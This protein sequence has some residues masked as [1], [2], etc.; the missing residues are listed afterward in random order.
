M[1][2]AHIDSVFS[3]T[4]QNS[5]WGRG[6]KAG[7]QRRNKINL[8]QTSAASIIHL[9]YMLLYAESTAEILASIRK[10]GSG[11][12]WGETKHWAINF[13]FVHKLTKCRITMTWEI[14]S[15]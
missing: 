13:W 14:F 8:F 5:E 10:A 6:K 9:V 3:I 4:L 2:R 1:S 15:K 12:G 11:W 7:Q